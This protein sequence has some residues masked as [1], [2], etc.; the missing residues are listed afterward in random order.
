CD[1]VVEL[2]FS[3]FVKESFSSGDA[4]ACLGW[5]T[6]G[7]LGGDDKG[8]HLRRSSDKSFRT[9][10][11]VCVLESNT[12]SRGKHCTFFSFSPDMSPVPGRGHS[13]RCG[14]AVCFWNTSES[15]MYN[16][17]YNFDDDGDVEDE[18]C[19]HT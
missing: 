17:Y 14:T 11:P 3:N 16:T 13:K 7:S 1:D 18:L 10:S 6:H 2:E 12:F 4:P 8:E 5:G 19:S 9:T 15:N